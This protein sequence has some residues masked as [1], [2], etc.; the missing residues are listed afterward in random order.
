[1]MTEKMLRDKSGRYAYLLGILTTSISMLVFAILGALESIAYTQIILL[2]PGG[3][4]ILQIAAGIV[5]FN[6]LSKNIS[7]K[8]SR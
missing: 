2:Y 6:H 4:L 1:M 7:T 8:K 5:L 3:Y